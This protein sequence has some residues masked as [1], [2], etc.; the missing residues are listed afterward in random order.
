MG[1]SRKVAAVVAVA[2]AILV[3]LV[4]W[5]WNRAPEAE[6]PGRPGGTV[7]VVSTRPA[8]KVGRSGPRR[9][10]TKLVVDPASK[11][12]EDEIRAVLDLVGIDN[13]ATEAWTKAINDP[14][15]AAECRT[16]LIEDL[17]EAGFANPK[18][19]AKDDLPLIVGRIQLIDQLAGHAM[20]QTNAA[21]FKE[22]RKDLEEMRGQVG[23]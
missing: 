13:E 16:N 20:D 11:K 21:A 17:N 5:T 4:W 14:T 22:A 15:L 3:A 1:I 8:A 2:L 12:K 10:T 18:Q 23:K 7:A 9:A 6:V 19:M